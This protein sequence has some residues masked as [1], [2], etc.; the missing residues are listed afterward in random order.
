MFPYL[1]MFT[2]RL[3]ADPYDMRAGEVVVATGPEEGCYRVSSSTTE[4]E[5][6]VRGIGEVVEAVR[7]LSRES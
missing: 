2:I 3:A 7:D 4:G 1:S 6:L 5:R